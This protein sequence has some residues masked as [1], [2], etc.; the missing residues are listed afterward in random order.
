MKEKE[1]GERGKGKS[2]Y[3]PGGACVMNGPG[4]SLGRHEEP[5]KREEAIEKTVKRRERWPKNG[6]GKREER[7][8]NKGECLGESSLSTRFGRQRTCQ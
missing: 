6:P 4:T 2:Q 7:K 8:R 5:R 3:N 1:I